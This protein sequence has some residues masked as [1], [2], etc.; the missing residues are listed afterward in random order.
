MSAGRGIVVGA[1]TRD[2]CCRNCHHVWQ[3][4]GMPEAPVDCPN[5]GL[6]VCACGCGSDLTQMR[7]DSVYFDRGHYMRLRRADGATQRAA[8]AHVAS[9]GVGSR[10]GNVRSRE[11]ADQLHRDF[12]GEWRDRIRRHM[13]R[14]LLATGHLHADDLTVL[15]VPAA[16][17]NVAGSQFGGF[18]QQGFMEST[19]IERK[20]AHAAANARKG[21]IF[22]ITE[23]GKRELPK[24][25]AGA[26]AEGEKQGEGA[27]EAG[28][29]SDAPST[30]RLTSTDAPTP[31]G[32]G[33]GEALPGLGSEAYQHLQDAA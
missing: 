11:Q 31:S 25:L 30:G 33:S 18:C 17:A 27:A 23:K 10:G 15:E 3:L 13:A 29:S 20:V 24:M 2:A 1:T 9:T 12:K 26:G 21:K 14:T 28:A 4:T 32:V 5:C 6:H 7:A 8:R 22:R 16:H 19:G